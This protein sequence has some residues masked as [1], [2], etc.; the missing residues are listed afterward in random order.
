MI[1][2]NGVFLQTLAEM[3]E[4]LAHE[5]GHHWTLSY[6]AVE[7]NADYAAERL[8]KSYYRRRGLSVESCRHDYGSI[9]DEWDR[10]D[11]EI[12]AED[13]RALFAPHPYNKDHAMIDRYGAPDAGVERYIR[14]LR[15]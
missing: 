4:T 7:S 10:C 11:K 5:Y 12:L 2:L 8:A 6:W 15:S 14:S 3:K 1:V 13:Y 9:N